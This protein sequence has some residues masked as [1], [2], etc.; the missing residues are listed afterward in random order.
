MGPTRQ[1]R[2]F[3]DGMAALVVEGDIG[4]EN[5]QST[6]GFDISYVHVW[7]SLKDRCRYDKIDYR[8]IIIYHKTNYR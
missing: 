1:R 2:N 4:E 6:P 7:R 8:Q 5:L 3:L